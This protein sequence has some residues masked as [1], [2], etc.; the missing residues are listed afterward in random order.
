MGNIILIGFMGCGKTS[1]GKKLADKLNYCFCDVDR[2]I[3]RDNK[4]SIP[5]IFES[6]GEDYFR[7]L[8]T[9]AI[10]NLKDT[11]RNCI[12]SVG[13]GLPV[14]EENRQILKEL[15]TV[16]YLQ[17]PKN[18]IIRRLE[19]DT[20]RPILQ[21]VNKEQ[22]IEELMISREPMYLSAADYVVNGGKKDFYDIIE[23][24]YRIVKKIDK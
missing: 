3:E 21:N 7:E 11:V 13:G 16:V 5:D 9:K 2:M 4:L 23:E 15:G 6:Y 22:I 10:L 8:E 12:I 20:S 14:R 19:H 18:I 1:I 24:V 17:V